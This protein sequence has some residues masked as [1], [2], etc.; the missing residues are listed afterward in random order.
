L[1]FL[2]GKPIFGGVMVT[3]VDSIIIQ[4]N[5]DLENGQSR[6][7]ENEWNLSVWPRSVVHGW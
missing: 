2:E 1:E 4:V 6:K 7:I 5:Y 3:P